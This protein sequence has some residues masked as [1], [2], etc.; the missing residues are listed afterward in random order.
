[1]IGG[2]SRIIGNGKLGVAAENGY[3]DRVYRREGSVEDLKGKKGR[4]NYK[5]EKSVRRKKRF[6]KQNSVK[7]GARWV[8]V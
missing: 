7:E 1:V 8:G 4:S 3:M 2:N 5:E 6:A